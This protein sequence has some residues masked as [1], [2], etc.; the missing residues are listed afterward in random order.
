MPQIS[1]RRLNALL[2]G[3][4]ALVVVALLVNF[5]MAPHPTRIYEHGPVYLMPSP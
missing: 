3:L 1:D 5:L 4:L 2:L